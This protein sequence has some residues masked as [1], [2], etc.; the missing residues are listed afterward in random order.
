M[1]CVCLSFSHSSSVCLS[2]LHSLFCWQTFTC[3]YTIYT[4][5]QTHTTYRCPSLLDVCVCLSFPFLAA[6]CACQM[7]NLVP[8]SRLSSHV[9]VFMYVCIY[10]YIY[11]YKYKPKHQSTWPILIHTSVCMS[12]WYAL[13][14][15][16]HTH[17]TSI[18][19]YLHFPANKQQILYIAT[20]CT[21]VVT[22]AKPK[23]KHAANSVQGSMPCRHLLASWSNILHI[24]ECES[25]CVDV[26]PFLI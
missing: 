26:C 8:W 9:F 18:C 25:V 7:V 21:H 20:T 22:H 11:V 24:C 23:T 12:H 15:C 13:S 5:T 14:R 6:V 1:V 19:T 3:I 2:V 16:A 4:H 10:I 17:I